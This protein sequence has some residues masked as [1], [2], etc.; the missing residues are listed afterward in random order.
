MHYYY[1]DK[2]LAERY[3]V[4]RCTIWGWVKK[5]LLPAPVKLSEGCTRFV[6]SEIEDNDQRRKSAA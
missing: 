4:H 3:K 5:G 1:T 2:E 6:G